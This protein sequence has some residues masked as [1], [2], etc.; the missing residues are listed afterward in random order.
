MIRNK[1]V[2][3]KSVQVTDLIDI[4]KID[5]ESSPNAYVDT[6]TG[7]RYYMLPQIATTSIPTAASGNAGGIVYD[8]TSNTVKFSNGSSWGNVST[9]GSVAW[10]DI[11][12]PDASSSVS[13]AAYTNT[14]TSATANWGGTI[15]ENTHSNPTTGATLL[16]LKYTANGDAEGVY[17]KCIDNASADT[18]FTIGQNGNT[19]IAGTATGTDALTITAGDITVTSGDVTMTDGDLLLSS[20]DVTITGN[21]SVSGTWT[22]DAV[23]ASTAATTLLLDGKTT[24]GVNICSLST[25]GITLSDDVAVANTKTVTIAGVAATNVFTITAGDVVLSDASITMT[26]ADNATSL[27][28]TNNTITDQSLVVFNSSSLTSGKGISMTANAVTSGSMIYRNEC[29]NFY[30]ILY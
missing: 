23:A 27:S 3:D 5:L 14:L 21:L 2:I 20:G 30:R 16:S 11:G 25:G 10:D 9:A 8:S 7:N 6:S 28:L 29:S 1:N 17:F 13:F 4:G 18:Q 24:G 26:D 12:D 22:I 15:L 19:V